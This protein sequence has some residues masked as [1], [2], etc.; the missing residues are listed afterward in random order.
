M[1]MSELVR[2]SGLYQSPGTEG[3]GEE[4]GL[5]ESLIAPPTTPATPAAPGPPAGPAPPP[6]PAPMIPRRVA[7][8]QAQQ[9]AL[10]KRW[11]LT[12]KFSGDPN[13]VPNFM[14]QITI[15][16]EQTGHLFAS[17]RER[18]LYICRVFTGKA[19]E[20]LIQLRAAQAPEL[21][22]LGGFLTAL[23]RRFEDAGLVTQARAQLSTMRQGTRSLGEY[24]L[25]FRGVAGLLPDWPEQFK[26][27][28]FQQGMGRD[29]WKLAFAWG[30]PNSLDGW[31]QHAGN[32]E[33]QWKRID[34]DFGRRPSALAAT[35]RRQPSRG[36]DERFP[37][38]V[39]R[40]CFHCGEPGHLA[41]SCP[42][43][44]PRRAG[45]AKKLAG[46]AQK[47][48][49][50]GKKG[51]AA[52]GTESPFPDLIIYKNGLVGKEQEASVEPD[53]PAHKPKAEP[54]EE[55]DDSDDDESIFFRM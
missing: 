18:A 37:R 10:L 14:A 32:V 46:A 2:R 36:G 41:P 3:E 11:G 21:N 5:E 15:C 1:R 51:T 9:D 39:N 4:E 16:M 25:E 24:V 40:V 44:P 26:I 34:P 22:Y 30:D 23:R 20:W 35:S 6:A 50:K 45:E 8:I 29:L 38:G 12:E 13:E 17:D 27:D 54:E 53:K 49:T 48:G 19:G 28:C 47:P 7:P 55:E 43:L 42:K 31:I 33:A 52:A